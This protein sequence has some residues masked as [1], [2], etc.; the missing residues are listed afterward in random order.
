MVTKRLLDL[1]YAIRDIS[2][3]ADQVASQGK[4]I[5]HLNIGDPVIF[6]FPTPA[7][8][9]QALYDAA[10]KGKNFY[11]DSLGI[12]ELREK[13]SIYEGKKNS[14]SVD[15]NDILITSGVTEAI[16][17]ILS[18]LIEERKE[19]LIPGPT[20]PV[21]LNYTKFFD[22]IPVEYE[23]DEDEDWIPNI[24][25][26]RTK[27]SPKTQGILICSPNNP[28][29]AIFDEKSIRQIVDIAG[30]YDLPIIS[31]EIYDQITFDQAIISPAAISTDVPVLV[32]N[33]FSKAHLSTGWRLG[34]LH[35]RDPESKLSDLKE[36][37]EKLARAR[38]CT[39]SLAQYAAL[40]ALKIPS[41]HT[42]EM[43]RKL[44]QRRDYSLERLN[45]ID[46]M[47]CR[48]ASGAFYLFPKLNLNGLKRWNS[49]KDFVIHL[50]K[51]TG[52]CAV[53]GSGFGQY[54]KNHFRVTFLP[55]LEILRQVY[56]LLEDFIASK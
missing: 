6:D 34:Y 7:P 55:Q 28:T 22:G 30:E 32:L 43:V 9:I 51:S 12:L 54:G 18:G 2:V 1:E 52:I 20:Y 41:M 35:Y 17:F 50:L 38:L 44:K 47:T 45:Q 5:Y 29:G 16:F 49:D 15:P 37:I 40:E 19:L 26:L 14:I 46:G 53:Y 27:I 24:E 3:I 25:D 36:A 21:Y 48:S 31:D 11:I 10:K 8:V 13:I 23:L 4:H 33:G 39:N 42:K 56:D